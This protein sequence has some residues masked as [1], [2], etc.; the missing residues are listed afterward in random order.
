MRLI[1]EQKRATRKSHVQP[2][3]VERGKNNAKKSKRYKEKYTTSAYEHAIKR[4]AKKANVE[5]WAPNQTRHLFATNTENKASREVARILLGHVNQ[6]T[7]GIYIDDDI[8]K[9]KNTAKLLE[10]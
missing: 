7:T 3:Q 1:R 2:S 4:A 9:V 5:L 6:S 8:Q 10:N